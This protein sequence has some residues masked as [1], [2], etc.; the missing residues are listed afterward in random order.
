MTKNKSPQAKLFKLWKKY[1]KDS[2]LTKGEQTKR[3]RE[4][5]RKGMKP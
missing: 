5:S 1:L 2:R 3:A 4:F